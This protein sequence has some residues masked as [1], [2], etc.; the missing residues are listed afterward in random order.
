MLSLEPR[1]FAYLSTALNIILGCFLC[2]RENLNW[3]FF[4]HDWLSPISPIRLI[5]PKS[6]DFEKT[7]VWSAIVSGGN[8]C[9]DWRQEWLGGSGWPVHP[10]L[11]PCDWN[12]RIWR[13]HSLRL[14]Q[15]HQMSNVC[16]SVDI[17]GLRHNW[18]NNV[19]S[20]ERHLVR[21][22]YV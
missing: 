19:M 21:H 12:L 11:F 16:W 9:L 7:T 15:R 17:S 4:M 22:R 13:G 2:L 6:L 20:W 14:D 18:T 3:P 8:G 5:S 1:S 10:Q